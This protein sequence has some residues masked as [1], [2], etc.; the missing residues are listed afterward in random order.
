MSNPEPAYPAASLELGESGNVLL[1][2][3]VSAEGQPTSVEISRS[4]GYGRLDRAAL[5][6]VKR[7]E[8]K[9]YIGTPADPVVFDK[10]GV[11]VLGCNI[12]DTMAAWTVIVETPWF[13]TTGADGRAK[14]DVPAGA[15][16]LLALHGR[17][18]RHRHRAQCARRCGDGCPTPRSARS[19]RA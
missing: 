7:F 11:A 3:A 6:A 15:H 18:G 16:Q 13:A 8:I 5:S 17:P 12:H 19:G 2:V 10:P 4:S 1:R 9:L 14:L